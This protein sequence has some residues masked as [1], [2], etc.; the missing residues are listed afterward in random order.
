MLVV[1]PI[2]FTAPW[3]LWGLLV[4]PVLWL[5]LRAVPPAPVRRRFPGV[6]LLLGLTDEENQADR[7]PWWL[8]MIRMVAVALVI[9]GFAGPLLHPEKKAEGAGPL[10]ILTDGSWATAPDRTRVNERITGLLDIADASQEE[11]MRYATQRGGVLAENG[12]KR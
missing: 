5:L 7:T 12:N 8:L 10:L 9:L 6:A 2:G 11:I 1:G 3:L 4:L